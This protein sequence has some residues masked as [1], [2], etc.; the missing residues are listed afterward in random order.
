[1]VMLFTVA[2]TPANC[3]CSAALLLIQSHDC[4]T[5]ITAAKLRFTVSPLLSVA[6]ACAPGTAVL[7]FNNCI[8][9]VPAV[10][11]INSADTF[12]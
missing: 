3:T 5:S 9:P 4:K 8:V 1:M 6:A 2:P 12:T 7:F 10:V 11:P